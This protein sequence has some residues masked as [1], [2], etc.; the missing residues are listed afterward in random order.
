MLAAL[1]PSILASLSWANDGASLAR[2]ELQ[3]NYNALKEVASTV[4]RS[5]KAKTQL[6]TKQVRKSDNEPKRDLTHSYSRP[7]PLATERPAHVEKSR[8]AG[9]EILATQRKQTCKG[10]EEVGLA[11]E[12]V[13]S[14]IFL[15]EI[16][17]ETLFRIVIEYFD[18]KTHYSTVS[19]CS[20]C[21]PSK[22]SKLKVALDGER[23][24][25][26]IEAAGLENL[27]ASF[28]GRSKPQLSATVSAAEGSLLM[29]LMTADASFLATSNPRQA[30]A[31]F[32][33]AAMPKQLRKVLRNLSTL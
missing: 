15:T 7:M 27:R 1:Y 31:R 9:K 13:N 30:L 11:V 5:A 32:K 28:R 12:R 6:A 24:Y 29:G 20:F 23:V 14:S 17:P 10:G 8:K 19:I 18:P 25:I 16:L 3:P 4:G 33:V 21:L 2:K 26:R 22:S